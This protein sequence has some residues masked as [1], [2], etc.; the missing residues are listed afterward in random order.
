MC[1]GIFPSRLSLT[2]WMLVALVEL[3]LSVNCTPISICVLPSGLFLREKVWSASLG[4]QKQQL[5]CGDSTRRLAATEPTQAG[6]ATPEKMITAQQRDGE[7]QGWS[8]IYMDGGRALLTL[9]RCRPTP[10]VSS[11]LGN[12]A[13]PSPVMM[14]GSRRMKTSNAQQLKES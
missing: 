12:K 4:M 7:A 1:F 8:R 14:T 6:G 9:A 2:M 11:L 10:Q 5:L 13:L 3:G